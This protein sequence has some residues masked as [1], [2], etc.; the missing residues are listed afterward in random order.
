MTDDMEENPFRE[1]RTGDDSSFYTTYDDVG[2]LLLSVST[3]CISNHGMNIALKDVNG[4]VKDADRKANDFIHCI[5][6]SQKKTEDP[7]LFSSPNIPKTESIND[8]KQ[9]STALD[10]KR[11]TLNNEAFFKLVFSRRLRSQ[12][13]NF[14]LYWVPLTAVYVALVALLIIT[15]AVLYGTNLEHQKEAIEYDVAEGGI[16]LIP[17]DAIKIHEKLDDCSECSSVYSEDAQLALDHNDDCSFQSKAELEKRFLKFGLDSTGLPIRDDL[18]FGKYEEATEFRDFRESFSFWKRLTGFKPRQIE[19]PHVVLWDYF[20]GHSCLDVNVTAGDVVNVVAEEYQT[21]K[22]DHETNDNRSYLRLPSKWSLVRC[23]TGKPFQGDVGL[24]PSSW[25]VSKDFYTANPSLFIKPKWFLGACC[26]SVAYRYLLSDK[27][28]IRCGM[29]VIFS[30][31]WLNLDPKDY[32]PFFMLVVCPKNEKV[33]GEM[34]ALA[35]EHLAAM[36]ANGKLLSRKSA[37]DDEEVS[38]RKREEEIASLLTSLPFCI[39]RYTIQRSRIGRY[40][41]H[42]HQYAS[43][44][45]LVHHLRT[46]ESQLPQP[47][48]DGPVE[49]IAEI[50]FRSVPPPCVS[51][52]RDNYALPMKCEQWAARHFDQVTE[53]ALTTQGLSYIS[54]ALFDPFKNAHRDYAK[55]CNFGD[56]DFADALKDILNYRRPTP[57]TH[58]PGDPVMEKLVGDYEKA[59]K[60]GKQTE[61]PTDEFVLRST[62]SVEIKMDD[63]QFNE[64]DA[65]GKGAFATVYKGKVKTGNG[66]VDSAIK[67]LKIVA[68]TKDVRHPWIAE[69]EMLQMISHPNCVTFYGYCYD[70]QQKDVLLAFELMSGAL[71][72]YIQKHLH[73]VSINERIGFMIQIARGMGHLHAMDP[74]IIHGDLAARNVL[75]KVHPFDESRFILKV[76]DFGLSKLNPSDM[77]VLPDDPDTIPFNWLAPETW[78]HREFTAKTDVWTFGLTALEI[79]GVKIPFGMTDRTI[80]MLMLKEGNRHVQPR[81]LPDYVFEIVLKCWR[82]SAVDRPTFPEIEAMLNPLYLEFDE[83]HVKWVTDRLFPEDER[84]IEEGPEG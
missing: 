53:P 40:L 23:M 63:F 27:P 45:D 69:I 21:R 4:N 61:L 16:L 20:G 26:L 39:K 30:P 15:T 55:F 32:R 47:L 28:K 29:F 8:K 46:S 58:V 41:L 1:S 11:E 74:Q 67:R 12:R 59:A 49:D 73:K 14:F 83:S 62:A 57:P 37:K 10:L 44:Y 19:V 24:I 18:L 6:N 70:E 42:G 3:S 9:E 43:L 5:A 72:S 80:I 84:C 82:K 78:Y 52:H 77:H 35:A 2:N 79:F 66:L 51:L 36:K 33:V 17:S 65:L 54:R 38:E 31:Q 48:T 22:L 81:D 71:D 76:T 13:P 34:V 50:S 7:H 68:P 60:E 64:K 75:M 56:T 25:I